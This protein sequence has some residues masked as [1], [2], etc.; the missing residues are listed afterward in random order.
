MTTF[1]TFND[2]P[3]EI[4][5]EIRKIQAIPANN[6]TTA[7]AAVL[8]AYDAQINSEVLLRNSDNEIVIAIGKTATAGLTGF[9]KGAILMEYDVADGLR[10]TYVNVGTNSATVWDLVGENTVE[11]R[12]ATAAGDGT[13][14]ISAYAKHVTVTSDDANKIITLPAPVVGKQIVIN[15]GA[16]GFELRTTAPATIAI[17]GGS[18][19]NAES[20]I[21]ANST[22]IAICISATAWKAIFLDADS[23]V[24]KVE[25]AA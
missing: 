9:A 25:A 15:V 3:V 16:T 19:A 10:G 5:Q 20:A 12:T 23:D 21:A 11:A 22:I 17:N 18:G 4:K 2:L 13:G 8:T 24:A 14:Q 1:E 6:R 7:Q